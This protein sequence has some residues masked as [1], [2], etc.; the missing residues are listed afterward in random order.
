MRGAAHTVHVLVRRSSDVSDL[1]HDV[2]LDYGGVTDA[3]SH[4]TVVEL[5]SLPLGTATTAVAPGSRSSALAVRSGTL[6][7]WQCR[8]WGRMPA[9]ALRTVAGSSVGDGSQQQELGW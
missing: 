4:A 9:S 6:R 7:R 5:W 8:C 3:E 2:D 1:P